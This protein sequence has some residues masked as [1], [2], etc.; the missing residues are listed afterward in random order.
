MAVG[1]KN[2][3]K[4]ALAYLLIP[5]LY[6]LFNKEEDLFVKFHS[7]QAVVFTIASFVVSVILG[8]IPIIGWALSPLWGLTCFAMWLFLMLKAYQGEEYKIPWLTD[9]VLEMLAK[10]AK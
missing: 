6:F 4:A 2:R 1:E 7:Q 3:Q 5:A 10:K 9:F 8:F